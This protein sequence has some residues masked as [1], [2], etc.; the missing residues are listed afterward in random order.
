M[1]TVQKE[2]QPKR[3]LN[4]NIYQ[5][6]ENFILEKEHPCVMAQTVFSME[7]VS[8]H[9][10]SKLGSVD[11]ACQIVRDLKEYIKNYDFNSNDFFAFV[12]VFKG[13]KEYTE[14]EF[15]DALWQQL[16]L[17]HSIDDRPWDPEVSRDSESNKFS[18]SIAGKAFY[19]VGMHPGSSRMARQ[20]PY[21][22]I[23]LNLH[24]QFEK[25]REMGSFD[26]VRNRIR[27]RD[28]ELQGTNNPM[29]ENFGESSEARQYSGR[30]V[31]DQWKCPFHHGNS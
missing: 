19:V 4:K 16:N 9:S 5:E 25:L 8:L 10:Y 2:L 23:V 15:E 17:I 1:N 26:V 18:F 12:A 21:P 29:L 24:C 14:K 30:E 31:G 3:P 6:F 7:Q 11:S 13:R 22:A 27:A 28:K 20:S